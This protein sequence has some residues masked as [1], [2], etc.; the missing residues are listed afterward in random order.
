MVSSA[1]ESPV[2]GG[3]EQKARTEAVDNANIEELG[4]RDARREEA[5]NVDDALDD[6][7]VALV[8]DGNHGRLRAT[9]DHGDTI[10]A[11]RKHPVRRGGRHKGRPAA[12]V[13]VDIERAAKRRSREVALESD[14]VEAGD[15]SRPGKVHSI[16]RCGRDRGYGAKRLE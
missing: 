2:E 16:R 9:I 11:V 14:I 3:A 15:S 7:S 12:S 13:R 8:D 6:H 5:T 1:A 4:E 10:G